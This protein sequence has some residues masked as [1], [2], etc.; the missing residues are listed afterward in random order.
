[1]IKATKNSNKNLN[2]KKK[3]LAL[4]SR[5]IA[6]ILL[7]F[8]LSRNDFIHMLDEKL[9]LE[10]QKQDPKASKLALAIRTGIDRRYI[11][12][13]LKGEI[14]QA[15]PDKLTVILEDILWTANHFYHSTKIPKIGAFRTFQSICEQRASGT[16]TYKAILNELVKNGNIIDHGDK[17]ELIELRKILSKNDMFYTDL[18][19]NQIN[20]ITETLIHNSNTE[21]DKN[22]FVQRT[23]F[24]T[25]INPNSF[26]NL[27]NDLK[28]ITDHHKNQITEIF[29]RYEED[30]NIGTHP[31]YGYSFLEY[32]IEK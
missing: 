28:I 9:V 13:H 10:A 7:K 25:Q 32:N 5:A 20:R 3:S 23:V 4:L 19:I 27:H 24:S 21:L 26:E 17:V 14:P 1:M 2:L 12:K 31:E 11:S 22:R 16:L 15:K 6:K 29:L 18:T 8:R 30:V